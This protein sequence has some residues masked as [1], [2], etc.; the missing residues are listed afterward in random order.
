[1]LTLA[2]SAPY[3]LMTYA[4]SG[5]IYAALLERKERVHQELKRILDSVSEEDQ[6]LEIQSKGRRR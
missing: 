1:M 5:I 3:K 6:W 4:D 2:Y